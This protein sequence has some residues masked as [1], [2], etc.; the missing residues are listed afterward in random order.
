MSPRGLVDVVR[1][2]SVYRSIVRH[3]P[4]TSDLDRSLLVTSN[5]FLHLHPVKIRRHALRLTYTFGLGGTTTLLF[6]ILCLTGVALMFYYAPTPER[7]YRSMQ[8][9]RYVVPYGTFLRNLHHWA[10]HAMIVAAVLHMARVFYTGAFKGTRQFNW[11]V[12][13]L[14]FVITLAF[15]FTGYL[16]PWDQ[17]A[18]W[19][20][21][22]GTNMAAAVPVLG[23]PIRFA[24]LGG[25]IVGA[26]ALLR[27]YVLH[28]AVLPAVAFLLLAVHFWR[29][30]KD[31]GIS[32]P[33]LPEP[34]AEE[35]E[36][37]QLF[38]STPGRSYALVALPAEVPT[39]ASEAQKTPEDTVMTYPHLLVREAAAAMLVVGVL[40]LLALLLN[41]PLEEAANALKT[42]DPAKAP[43]YF[44]GLQEVVSWS[45]PFIGGVLFPGLMVLGLLA[46]PYFRPDP[47]GSGVWFHPS[48]RRAV[49]AFTTVAVLN[50]VL[51]VIGTFFRG[52]GWSLVWPW[53]H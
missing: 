49:I 30:R 35:G 5:V 44:L 47:S 53:S 36:A 3:G 23:R 39:A 21:T 51:I 24:L 20:V 11:V 9:L 1:R 25:N 52:H 40:A 45:T 4:P 32:G 37:A 2:S 27:F 34:A 42:P 29:V 10:A 6:A 38:A 22:V 26:N 46:I 50:V 15:S 19:A 8:D 43:W 14:L 17:L 28:C 33:P 48:R 13:V 31:G 7:A 12:G 16:L 18:F 41:A